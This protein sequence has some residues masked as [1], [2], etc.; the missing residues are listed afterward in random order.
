MPDITR[1][2]MNE[3]YIDDIADLQL[4][5][6]NVITIIEKFKKVNFKMRVVIVVSYEEIDT[7]PLHGDI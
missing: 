2:L 6:N 1:K 5:A 4:V 3:Y 7:N